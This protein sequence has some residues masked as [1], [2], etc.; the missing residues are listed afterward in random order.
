MIDHKITCN[1]VLVLAGYT[2]KLE[3]EGNSMTSLE[4]RFCFLPPGARFGFQMLCAE[5][6][7]QICIL[8]LQYD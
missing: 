7:I 5:A 6:F 1:S 4:K 2:A 3:E 8:L